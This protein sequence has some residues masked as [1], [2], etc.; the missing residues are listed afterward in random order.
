M[1]ILCISELAFET[2]LRC[3]LK[4]IWPTHIM[5]T[6]KTLKVSRIRSKIDLTRVLFWKINYSFLSNSALVAFDYIIATC[7][8]RL[9]QVHMILYETPCGSIRFLAWRH[10][11]LCTALVEIAWTFYML[12]GNMKANFFYKTWKIPGPCME[13]FWRIT[14]QPSLFE[15]K[16]KTIPLLHCP[17]HIVSTRKFLM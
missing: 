10:M 2:Q 9:H 3:S 1:F 5:Y 13:T 8:R 12:H 17:D 16:L 14:M 4:N 6:V 15:L 11:N 7:F